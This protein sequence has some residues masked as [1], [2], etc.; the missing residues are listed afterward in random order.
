VYVARPKFAVTLF[1][2]FP[3]TLQAPVPVQAPVQPVNTEPSSGA[4]VTATVVPVGICATQEA[5]AVVQ[6]TC[7]VTA[8]E[9]VPAAPTVATGRTVRA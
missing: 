1:T 6:L 5:W 9:T 4:A 8:T 2:A 3:S 7:G